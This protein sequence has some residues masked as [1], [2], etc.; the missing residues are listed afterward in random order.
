MDR[1]AAMLWEN[2]IHG[3]LPGQNGTA[4][5]P[6]PRWRCKGMGA[7]PPER[8]RQPTPEPTPHPP[9][10]PLVPPGGNEAAHV[11]E[12]EGVPSDCMNIYTHIPTENFLN[13]D[14]YSKNRK[15][16]NDFIPDLL[17]DERRSTG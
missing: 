7:P 16:D 13:L 12:I 8:L 6:Q 11:S 5:N 4:L 10:P 15:C 9:K 17:T 2:Q 1:H 3:Y 14:A